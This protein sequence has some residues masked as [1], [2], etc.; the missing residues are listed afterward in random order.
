[1]SKERLRSARKSVNLMPMWKNSSIL[2]GCMLVSLL[3]QVNV[4]E[5]MGKCYTKCKIIT[6]HLHAQCQGLLNFFVRQIVELL[7]KENKNKT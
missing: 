5:L 4:A 2:V 1:M 6:H 3:A 7:K